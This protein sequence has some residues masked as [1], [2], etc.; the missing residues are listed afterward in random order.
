ML[1]AAS[2]TAAR[3]PR[4][5]EPRPMP[6]AA[7]PSGGTPAG[8]LGESA[9][10]GVGVPSELHHRAHRSRPR[11]SVSPVLSRQ[12]VLKAVKD[13]L[14]HTAQFIYP[15]SVVVYEFL[16]DAQEWRWALGTVQQVHT[17]TV[18]LAEWSCQQGGAN[19]G[20]MQALKNERSRVQQELEDHQASILALRAELGAVRTR[21]EAD[22]N[23]TREAIE[24]RRCE[25]EA[26]E[27]AL[28]VCRQRGVPLQC[29]Y[30]D[31]YSAADESDSADDVFAAVLRA[32]LSIV[33][34]YV[35]AT[36]LPWPKVWATVSDPLFLHRCID[37]DVGYDMSLQQYDEI[38]A[39]FFGS[40]AITEAKVHR[41]MASMEQRMPDAAE[42]L[43]TVANWLFTQLAA[44][45][46]YQQCARTQSRADMLQQRL[47]HHVNALKATARKLRQVQAQLRV[48][49]GAPGTSSSAARS[50]VQFTF[51]PA[52]GIATDVLRCAIICPVPSHS[53]R[54][55]GTRVTAA[56][57]ATASG[58]LK[59]PSSTSK[60]AAMMT[61]TTSSSGHPSLNLD[62][63]GN[64]DRVGS[65][66]APSE[67][68][69]SPHHHR[70]QV[71]S[72]PCPPS[73]SVIP[74]PKAAT[75]VVLLG[76]EELE[77]I[78]ARAVHSRPELYQAVDDLLQE[79]GHHQRDAHHARALASE[80]AERRRRRRET[81]KS[82]AEGFAT[83]APWDA[84]P[85]PTAASSGPSISV[86]L[87]TSH[88]SPVAAAQNVPTM[89]F[90]P[91]S[92]DAA[93]Q[94]DDEDEVYEEE[95]DARAFQ[96]ALLVLQ[97]Q[98]Q[99]ARGENEQLQRLLVR[100]TDRHEAVEAELQR[101]LRDARADHEDAQ[102]RLA[103]AKIRA[104]ALQ[105]EC[106]DLDRDRDHATSRI[107]ALENEIRAL[108][109]KICSG[110]SAAPASPNMTSIKADKG[111][112]E[113]DSRVA[114]LE[115]ELAWLRSSRERWM[116]HRSDHSD[117]ADDFA[118]TH[119]H[120][121]LNGSGW[122]DALQRHPAELRRAATTDA[123]AACHVVAA[124]V[125]GV[126]FSDN[127]SRVE[128][129]VD[130]PS[131][132]TKRQLDDRLHDTPFYECEYILRHCSSPKTGEDLLSQQLADR[133]A[134]ITDLE[135]RLAKRSS[136]PVP[137]Q[138]STAE[139]TQQEDLLHLQKQLRRAAEEIEELNFYDQRR[140]KSGNG[141]AV[142]TVHSVRL[143]GED[144]SV[145]VQEHPEALREAFIADVS[146]ACHVTRGDVEHIAFGMGSLL[147]T[148]RVQHD[149][150]ATM[151]EMDRRLQ[152]YDYPLTMELYRV[153]HG[154][155]RGA[156]AALATLAKRDTEIADLREQLREAEERA[157]DVEAQQCD[158]DAEVADLREQLREA[159]ERTRDVEAQQY[160]R[161]AELER[162]K[163]LLSSSMRE[164]ECSG[165]IRGALE[166]Q[167]ED[168]AREIRELREQLAVAQVR[169]EALDAELADLREQLREAE[170]RARD[171][172]AQQCDRDAEV[173]DLREQL[174][175]AEERA[176]DV[177]AQQCDRD[178][179][180]A[181]LREQLREAEE[182][183]R[184]VEAQQCDRDAEL[185]D[186]RE[187]LREA[188]E[189]A[190]DVE[191]QQ[192]DRDA[193]LADLREQLR[194][195]EER[196][197]DVEAQQCDRDA[198]VADLRE[199]LREAEERARDVEAQQCDRDA[200]VADLREQLREAEE[201]ARDVEAQQCD[202]D[203]EV[204]DLRE[205]L[206][207]AEERTRDVEAQQCDRDAELAD[208]R[209]QLR[210]A[211]ERT[212]DV[213]AQQCDRDAELADL[214]E[215]LREAEER[216]RDVE[217]Q[218]CDRDAELADLREQLREAE[219]RTRDVEA[220]QCD[221][222]AE[223]AD[224]REQL[225]E[226]EERARD[227]EA[228][229]CDRDAE[230]A[231]L[232]EQLREAE[233]RARDVEAQQCDRDAEV[234]DLR[235]QLR[236]AEER[237]RDVEAQQCDRDAEVA[238]LR[239]Q[240][241][242]AEERARDVEAQQCDRDAELERVKEL[243]SS[244][245]R[246][247]ECSGEIRGALEDQLEDAA[248]EIRELREQ[249]AVA[250][251]RREALDAELADLREQLR[252]AE[253]RA[254]DVEAQ[255]CD[256]DAEV[257][258]LREQLRE[259]EERTRDVE[260]Q[261]CD[262][263]A[264]LAD[265]REQ[266]REAEERTRD[267][268]AQQCD[269]DAEVADLREQLREAEE[270]ARDVEA[271]Q[272]D[273]DAEVADLREQLREAEERARD[274]EAQQCDRDA[275]VADLREQLREAEERTRDV[276]AQQCDRDAELAD[277]R[278]QLREAEERTRDV[279]AQQC[280]RDAELADLREQ[281][282]EAEERAR[283]VE[284]QQCDRDAELADLR[285]QLREAEERTRDVEAQQCDRDAEVADL[286]EQLREAEERARDV[287]AQQCDRDAE[288]ADLR[289]QLREAEERARDVEAQQ[290]DRDAEVADLREQLREAEE[291]ARDVEAQQCD[292]DAEVADLREQLRE[293]EERARDVEAQQ[294]DRDAELERVKELLSSS[295]RE[296]EC[297]GEIRGALEDQLED[298]AREIRELR[299]QLAVAQVR[300]EALDAEL[301]D[302]REQLR[303]AEERARDVEAQQC[304][305]DAEVADL[306]EQLREAEERARD[307]EAQ[308]CD[309]DAELADLR[310]QLREAEERTRDVE[311]QQCDRDAEVADLREQLR[312]AEERARDVEAQQCDRDAEMER[313]KELLSGAMREAAASSEICRLLEK[314]VE[315]ATRDVGL[316]REQLAVAQVR[317]EALGDEC[318]ELQQQLL[319]VESVREASVWKGREALED[320]AI[321]HSGK[322]AEIAE[323]TEQLRR[324]AEEI[325][326]LN[327]YDQRRKKSGNGEAVV[328]VHSVRLPGEDWS[329]VVQEHPEA[330]REAFIADV[331]HACHVTRGDVE[332][333]AFGMGSLLATVRVQH[334]AD[335]T[336]MEMDR[337][338]QEYDYPL[339]MELYRVRHGPK[340]GA[341]A[342]LATLAKRDTELAELHRRLCDLEEETSASRRRCGVLVGA[343]QRCESVG[344]S[345]LVRSDAGGLSDAREGVALSV[346]A[347][348]AHV[349]GVILVITSE[350]SQRAELWRRMLEEALCLSET[351]TGLLVVSYEERLRAVEQ[352]HELTSMECTDML[353]RLEEFVN[354][355]EAARAAERAAV[356][357][358]DDCERELR[359]LQDRY[360]REVAANQRLF[361]QREGRAADR[362]SGTPSW[363]AHDE[364]S[365]AQ[366][367][368]SIDDSLSEPDHGDDGGGRSQPVSR[369]ARDTTS[370]GLREQLEQL[371]R[372]KEALMEELEAKGMRY[373][374]ALALLNEHISQLMEEL[375]L[376]LRDGVTSANNARALLLEIAELRAA[377]ERTGALAKGGNANRSSGEPSVGG[378]GSA[379][380]GGG[381]SGAFAPL[382]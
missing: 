171:V 227:V 132:V 46:V 317:R 334:D 219:E 12:D 170:E 208:L 13:R 270:R 327:F 109:S 289:E 236:E 264:E 155:K 94:S 367:G 95:A 212:R 213:E 77:E 302:L 318:A 43:C 357:S 54:H 53:R 322:D 222:D 300:R 210:E 121:R 250:Q 7:S 340:R 277:L 326:E 301:A 113:E 50:E 335:A 105:V 73:P 285:E 269:R 195:A 75:E 166:D 276:E 188:E 375:S 156:D 101:Q 312:E 323:L 239:E 199:Q 337:R 150:D 176:R 45:R 274:V 91:G 306:R 123:A 313:V 281:L 246:E 21:N 192:C 231:D 138:P 71:R 185:A 137:H 304:D 141:E 376:H 112:T 93:S 329:V 230:V 131:H 371:K 315:E 240:L 175:E 49:S 169:R 84:A 229:Q 245:M 149:A 348:V 303:E 4:L 316:L 186:L 34:D 218:Q 350:E 201:R 111:T 349:E 89:L 265:L 191:A 64:R 78:A 291:R 58:E 228:Q 223:V 165:E 290:C 133:N 102:N 347:D 275:E 85:G 29:T 211:E 24:A 324:A 382:R 37:Y 297:S 136:T 189:R 184:D 82:Q 36:P 168:A 365:G 197:R 361:L 238:D 378:R 52:Q 204:A 120:K 353:E 83:D 127:G 292:R 338:L 145:V 2:T 342:A 249:L 99:E 182:R 244:S 1:Y 358:R 147:A 220:Q 256:R 203:A 234:A 129:Y 288:V 44:F 243:L 235:E 104:E 38:E 139:L 47:T 296:A 125:T 39:H 282:R 374:D 287:E 144:W 305:R 314:Q 115:A 161:D 258:D 225:R 126:H 251:V 19:D 364:D 163:E 226:A 79:C 174:R 151:M 55:P 224:L 352:D 134:T 167:L 86:T 173:A 330:L 247:A 328:T 198:E 214:R 377:Q 272:C 356:D 320:L 341:D 5:A 31:G 22:M 252:E 325:E 51:V 148:V 107:S 333:I 124:A 20:V 59:S 98:L 65:A 206:R 100:E 159:E 48:F 381:S 263:D 179:E 61:A 181:D 354:L 16:N 106:E 237:A 118:T 35:P 260:A 62:A 295:M 42:F 370:E 196:T 359:A 157:R 70:E 379:L 351:W 242:E 15:G 310:E 241:R 114:Q 122:N 23:A 190:R 254:R 280:D 257:A 193:E 363:A 117:P 17:H 11:R 143:P 32:A 14:E 321:K 344:D 28:H 140:K 25:L 88:S 345:D 153:R 26:R 261:Q 278:E 273:R 72:T 3:R 81:A 41:A 205:Q 33:E 253:E 66:A 74:V 248:R 110:A 180:V 18:T 56:Q 332:H 152:E 97:Q 232:R 279:E 267:V 63:L 135:T 262:R 108:E 308:Q 9:P 200:E 27:G 177:E 283:D 373:R 116:P 319:D 119:H 130:H 6:T 360:D 209:E 271:Q 233:E 255:Q 164:A 293:A 284:A 158:R 299:E 372:E 87:P 336:M 286:R 162:V 298:A 207:E 331:S 80:R 160:D 68:A 90:L 266:L 217:A 355:L 128:F 268:E 57:T 187:Q 215:Q 92:K 369:T 40:G 69:R 343:M 259:A 216:A 103:G 146:H 76:H 8:S 60:G 339:T 183:T 30:K 96:S 221:R 294:C 194:E 362:V 346:A 309:R 10:R 172:E 368:S 154:P 142:V 366:R 380:W 307:V 202:R 178:A 67:S 311:A